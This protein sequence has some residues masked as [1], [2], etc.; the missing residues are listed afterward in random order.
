MA[1]A[2]AWGK[3]IPFYYQDCRNFMFLCR[4]KKISF[5]LWESAVE[6]T[7]WWMKKSTS[8]VGKQVRRVLWTLLTI[9]FV[10]T[11]SLLFGGW[12]F[13][14]IHFSLIVVLDVFSSCCV[15]FLFYVHCARVLNGPS[16]FIRFHFNFGELDKGMIIIS[17]CVHFAMPCLQIQA[18]CFPLW[19]MNFAAMLLNP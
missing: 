1:V 11:S 18:D 15:Y 10:V 3:V 5:R 8:G 12:Q 17:L 6:A 19:K 14:Y 7:W 13:F 16:V 9:K 2:G 4:R